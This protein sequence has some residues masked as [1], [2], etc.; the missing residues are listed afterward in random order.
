MNFLHKSSKIL[1][2]GASGTGKTEFFSRYLANTRAERR[3]IFDHEGEFQ[4]RFGL[5]A[6][7]DLDALVKHSEE[8]WT[9]FDPS[10]MFPGALP[11]AFDFFCDYVFEFSRSFPG[12]KIFACDELQKMVGTNT[13]TPELATILETGRRYELDCVFLS[14]QP[15][16]IHNRVRNQL[17]EIVTFAQSDSNALKFIEESGFDAESVRQLPEGSWRSRHTR[18]GI[19]ALGQLWQK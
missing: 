7:F 5:P 2:T 15:N 3:F 11:A 18:R 16:I 6:A 8:S 4:E 17:T 19:E 9:L 12:R 1:I 13:I 10:E 14:Q